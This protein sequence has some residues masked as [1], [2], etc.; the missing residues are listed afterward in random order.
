MS[1]RQLQ[2]TYRSHAAGM[3]AVAGGMLAVAVAA[4]VPRVSHAASLDEALRQAW[5][6]NPRLDAERANLAAVAEQVQ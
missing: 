1:N 5:L 3:L 4:A 6:S 2:H